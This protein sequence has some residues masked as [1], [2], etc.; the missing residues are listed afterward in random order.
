MPI[1]YGV[2]VVH[3]VHFSEI[4]LILLKAHKFW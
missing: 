3:M 4:V 1:K 2:V